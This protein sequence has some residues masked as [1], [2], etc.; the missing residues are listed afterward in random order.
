M[1]K[2]AIAVVMAA[3]LIAGVAPA[4]A[5]TAP[6][7]PTAAQKLQLQYLV[8][9]EKL[10]RDVYAYLAANVTSQKFSNITKS[11]QTHMDNISALL[12]KYNFFNPTLTRAPGVFRDAELQKLYNDLIAQGSVNL[13]AAMQVGVA[14]EELDIADLKKIMVT[15]APADVKLAYDLLLKGSY[16]HL[17]AFSR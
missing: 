6:T 4:E 7:R 5:A 9:E 14:I 2:S 13:A 15:P 12:K 10:A 3:G 16:N 1:R 17:A 8:E 11:E